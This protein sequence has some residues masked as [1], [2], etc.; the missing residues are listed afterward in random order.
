[1]RNP[2]F[3]NAKAILMFFVVL[4]HFIEPLRKIDEYKTLYKFVYLFHMPVFIF[5]S[6]YFAKRISLVEIVSKFIAPLIVFQIFYLIVNYFL[7]VQFSLVEALT[8]PQ[9]ALWYLL[10]LFCWVGALNLINEKYIKVFL[11]LSLLLPFV[12]G[13]FAGTKFSIGRTLYFFPFFLFGYYLKRFHILVTS[14]LERF[15]AL[16]FFGLLLF[17]STFK[18]NYMILFGAY[19]FK[20]S[21]IELMDGMVARVFIVVL[22]LISCIAFFKLIPHKENFFTKFGT[23]TLQIFILHFVVVKVAVKYI[24]LEAIPGLWLP[25]VVVLLTVFTYWITSLKVWGEMIGKISEGCRIVLNKIT[26][27][28][29]VLSN[30]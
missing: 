24:N 30:S 10:S 19:S 29:R 1:M 9:A 5:I 15:A 18:F 16:V 14:G 26:N 23:R 22:G 12:A 28:K 7:G 4:A 25:V 6:G 13:I 2:K 17:L 11:A 3:D 20:R 21:G 27:V 8:S